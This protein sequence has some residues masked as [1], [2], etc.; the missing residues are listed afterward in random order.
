MVEL[1]TSDTSQTL[2]SVGRQFGTSNNAVK[3]ALVA[4][5]VR[6]RNKPS[7]CKAKR[8]ERIRAALETCE[9][10]AEVARK[11]KITRQR[12]HQIVKELEA[13]NA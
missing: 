9:N 12:L 3:R 5:G 7:R 6:V 8:N 2:G 4:A 13:E 1:Y 10:Q 11:F